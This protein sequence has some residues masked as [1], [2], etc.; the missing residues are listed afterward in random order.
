VCLIRNRNCVPV[1][2]TCVHFRCFDGFHVADRSSFLCCVLSASFSSDCSVVRSL[3]DRTSYQVELGRNGYTE[4]CL[5]AYVG[6]NTIPVCA[7][8]VNF[9][10]ACTLDKRLVL[11][12]L[13]ERGYNQKVHFFTFSSYF[14]VSILFLAIYKNN[15][16]IVKIS[17]L[18]STSACVL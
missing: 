10:L 1:V 9:H 11:V 15:Y 4:W 2:C 6:E 16:I 14:V 8:V 13:R 7:Y 18:R 3:N 5:L 17:L 12:L